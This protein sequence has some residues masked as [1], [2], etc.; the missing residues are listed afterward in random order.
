M[1][2]TIY[3]H[4]ITILNTL[5]IMNCKYFTNWYDILRITIDDY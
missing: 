4:T 1:Y 2:K 3:I 5:E